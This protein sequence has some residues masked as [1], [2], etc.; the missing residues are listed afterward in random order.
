MKV[1]SEWLRPKTLNRER[2]QRV[3]KVE[4]ILMPGVQLQEI[5]I[6]WQGPDKVCWGGI[7]DLDVRSAHLELENGPAGGRWAYVDFKERGRKE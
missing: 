2:N 6:G 1:N 5:D 3:E 4:V 7:D